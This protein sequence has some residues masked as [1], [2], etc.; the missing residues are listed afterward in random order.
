ME[1]DALN[2]DIRILADFVIYSETIAYQQIINSKGI[3]LSY[4]ETGCA[5]SILALTKQQNKGSSGDGFVVRR[6]FS[7][8]LDEK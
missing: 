8:I 3:N 7:E 4:K 6:Y 2:Y 5:G 1:K